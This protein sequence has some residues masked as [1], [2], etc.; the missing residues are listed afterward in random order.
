MMMA[1]RS[2]DSLIQD[3]SALLSGEGRKILAALYA[4]MRSLRLY[5]LENQVVQRALAEVEANARVS[6]NR[7]GRMQLRLAGDFVFFND[8]RLRLDLGNYASFVFVRKILESHGVGNIDVGPGVDI[9]EWTSFLSLLIEQ[10]EE[11]PEAARTAPSPPS[12]RI[13]WGSETTAWRNVTSS[14]AVVPGVNAISAAPCDCS[15]PAR[16]SRRQA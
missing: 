13:S 6:L 7:E 12:S 4:T 8:I 2:E 16:S 15:M 10:P 14:S 5:P 9:R 11:T 1:T 3:T